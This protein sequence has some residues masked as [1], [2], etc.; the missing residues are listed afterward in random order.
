MTAEAR[1]YAPESASATPERVLLIAD[2]VASI[3]KLATLAAMDQTPDEFLSSV[4]LCKGID[5][6][7]GTKVG[8]SFATESR[9]A[10]FNYCRTTLN[11]AGL[12][13]YGQK[14]GVRGQVRAVRITPLGTEMWPAIA[15]AYLPWERRNPRL[16]LNQVIGFSQS[17]FQR[18]SSIRLDIFQHLLSN[19]D[20]SVTDLKEVTGTSFGTVSNSVTELCS[21]GLVEAE[22]KYGPEK[23]RFALDAPSDMAE[24]YFDLM[25]I[26]VQRAVRA[27]EAL[28]QDE[29]LET[30]GAT[31]IR[32]IKDLYPDTDP[33]A[34][35]RQMMDWM[36]NHRKAPSLLRE[37]DR[38]DENARTRLRVAQAVTRPITELLELRSELVND[39]FCRDEYAKR[40]L[41]YFRSKARIGEHMKRARRESQALNRRAGTDWE[42]IFYENVPVEG[43]SLD[44]LCTTIINKTGIR[45]TK[46]ALM[47]RVNQHEE[48]LRV[49]TATTQEGVVRVP[50]ISLKRHTFEPNWMRQAQCRQPKIDRSLFEEQ[51]ATPEGKANT[52]KAIDY[53]QQCPV[54]RACL[55]TAVKD[56]EQ[57]GVWGG[58]TA[59]AIQKLTPI[60]KVAIL[61]TV[62][63]K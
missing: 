32:K 12:V 45:I 9:T 5:E 21:Q 35:W 53:C 42:P 44:A 59:G 11:P 41:A 50:Q 55:K 10:P 1:H 2:T 17:A 7:Q 4:E 33:R 38:I 13:E 20:S 29:V 27:I 57:E 37:I 18:G 54:R 34:V 26:D 51:P 56:E 62:E 36:T 47:K 49:T 22:N 52:K 23:R 58:M 24:R 6:L 48:Q 63:I 28:K 61:H 30:D 3:S 15:G 39:P 19:P 43:I 8:W 31:I 46:K 40:G 14:E 60:Q 25:S 16:S